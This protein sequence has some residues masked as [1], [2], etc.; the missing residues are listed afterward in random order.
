MTANLFRKIGKKIKSVLTWELLV[1]Q[2]EMR[3]ELKYQTKLIISQIEIG[4][5]LLS[6]KYTDIYKNTPELLPAINETGFRVHSQFDEDGYLL[7]IF[8]II[9]TTTKTSI[10]IGTGNGTECN[11]SNLI[12]YHGWK[13]MLIDGNE[14][15]VKQG[16]LFFAN[17]PNVVINEPRFVHSL[18]TKDN[19]NGLISSNGFIGDV[20]LL[21]IDID[22]ND[23]YILEAI[24]CISPRVI[25]CEI[26]N[27]IP[28]DLPL[29]IPYK[30]DFFNTWDKEYPEN[31]FISMSLC[32]ANKLMKS[33]GYRLVAANR[34]GFNVIFMRN[35]TGNDIFPEI[36][37]EA[38]R[39]NFI[40]HKEM[41]ELWDSLKN[42]PWVTV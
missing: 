21:S 17:N 12:I 34:M 2:D 30:E 3:Q 11:S 25:I 5:R 31:S 4:Q 14:K 29:T 15:N 1:A 26:N 38:A 10:E 39:G 37:L 33:K 9:G 28:L 16:Q 18:V 7:Y 19:V 8:S 40:N 23:Y 20:D 6:L 13:G 41:S 22:G 42:Y 27:A 36:S 35:D 24:S 32:A